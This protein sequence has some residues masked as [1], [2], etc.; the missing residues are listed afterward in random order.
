MPSQKMFALFLVAMCGTASAQI[1]EGKQLVEPALIA[2]VNSVVPGQKFS[3]GVRLKMHPG[4]HTYWQ[5][6]G[7]SGMP[8][9]VDWELPPGFGASAI[10]WPLPEKMIVE[11]DL[12]TY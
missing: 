7:D 3:V 10:Q 1:F 6:S 2:N 9:S 8:T 5:Y 4:W 11:G 12:W